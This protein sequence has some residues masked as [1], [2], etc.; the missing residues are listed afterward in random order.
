VAGPGRGE[1]E[2][3]APQPFALALGM[4]GDVFQRHPAVIR[5]QHDERREAAPSS[6]TQAWSARMPAV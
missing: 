6:G 2:H 4:H 5:L 1:G 3:A